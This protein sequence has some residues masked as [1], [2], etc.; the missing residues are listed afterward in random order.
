MNQIRSWR[1]K[2]LHMTLIV[3]WLIVMVSLPIVRWTAGDALFNVGVSLSVLV[4]ASAVFVI[5][6][7]A[8][9]VKRTAIS[10]VIVALFA[11]LLEFIGSSTGF[12]FGDYTYTAALQPQIG[13]VPLLI[14][15]AWFMMLPV[16]W[17]VAELIV[18]RGNRLR[19]VLVSA[20]AFTAWDLF[21]DP[22]MVGWGYWIWHEP[23]GYFGIPWSNYLGW[24]LGA[25]LMTVVVAPRNLG[26][27]HLPLLLIYTLTWFLES[28]GLIFFWGQIGPGVVGLL[29][30]GA[31][32]MLAWRSWLPTARAAR[33]SS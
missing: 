10:A 2:P 5:V 33:V 11:W 9:G 29:A 32:L 8:W 25:M 12:P 23:S 16:A 21:L 27:V 15:L 31:F 20:L 4:Q 6:C 30:M 7:D 14:P 18:G 13:H 24:L 1:I 17:A 28:F 22:Q 3:A 19:F 26:R